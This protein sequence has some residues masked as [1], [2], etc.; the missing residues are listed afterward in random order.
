MKTLH[1]YIASD[2]LLTFAMTLVIFTFVMSIG[3]LFKITDL[4]ARGVAGGLILRIL[5][6][7]IP[8][9]LIFAIPISVLTSC[10]LV[11]GRL[12]AD[13]EVT[14]MRVSGVSVWAIVSRPLFVSLLFTAIC[15]YLNNDLAPRSHYAR[16]RYIGELGLQSPLELLEEGRF[17]QD[18]AG[19]TVYVGG[20]K[21]KEI[22]SIRIYDQRTEGVRR[23]IV[24]ESGTV[25]VSTNGTD[26]LL[27]LRDVRVDPISR[28]QPGVAYADRYTATIEDALKQRTYGKTEP[29]MTMAELVEGVRH[30]AIYFPNLNRE[31]LAKEQMSLAVEL[32]KRLALSFACI[33]FVLLG[34]PLGIKAHRKESSVGIAISLGV[35]FCFYLF[36][37]VT[38][39]LASRPELRPDFIVWLPVL[40]CVTLGSILIERAN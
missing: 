27:H 22:S 21:G 35:V 38:E 14:A 6:T 18:F 24:A 39:S 17:I 11:F 36:I 19:M 1:R 28:D 16:R 7:G 29:D 25:E 20:R 5:M 9:A 2:F 15:L 13:G 34:V 12:S 33:A 4:L 8:A 23:E 32:N 3:L 30:T 26:L 31:D 10:L 40:I 37:L